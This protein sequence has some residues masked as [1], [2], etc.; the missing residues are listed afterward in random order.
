MTD[1]QFHNLA[2]PEHPL[3]KEDPLRQVALRYQHYIR[4][5]P[6]EVYRTAKTD[7]GLYYTTKRKSDMGQ[8]RTPPLRYLEYTAP[9]MHN[10]VF[11]TLEEVIDFYDAGG[12]DDPTKSP[13]L[14]PLDLNEDE[15]WDLLIFLES[16]SGE[17]I[18]MTPPT[19]PRY[20]PT[21]L[22]QLSELGNQLASR[23]TNLHEPAGTRVDE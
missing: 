15:K 19:L 8:F 10:G 23:D 1:E 5:V 21:K 14:K 12:G 20:E 17:E 4:G 11:A 6:E 2:L 7:L 16:M 18:R 9:Y 22:T 3:F 13:L